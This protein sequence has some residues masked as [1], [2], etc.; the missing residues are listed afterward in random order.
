[1]DAWNKEDDPNKNDTNQRI[2]DIFF[3][4]APFL[5]MYTEYIK[6]FDKATNTINE[7]Y[8]KNKK[9]KEI[10]DDIHV[11]KNVDLY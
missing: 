10:M 5:K 7:T 9:F 1:M 11:S 4:L 3:N 6:D 8:E 2:G